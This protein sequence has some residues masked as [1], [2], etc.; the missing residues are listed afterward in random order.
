M[1]IKNN[2][3]DGIETNL[4]KPTKPSEDAEEKTCTPIIPF[5][6]NDENKV[7]LHNLPKDE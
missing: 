4:A 1:A 6:N 7:D 2:L 3:F 5:T